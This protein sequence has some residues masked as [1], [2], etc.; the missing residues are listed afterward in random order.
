MNDLMTSLSRHQ[1]SSLDQHFLTMNDSL[2]KP[3]SDITY[4]PTIYTRRKTVCDKS[5]MSKFK[6]KVPK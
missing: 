2:I 5:N 1:V 4:F 6:E 3:A